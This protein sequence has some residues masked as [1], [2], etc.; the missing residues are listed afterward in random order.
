ML[1]WNSIN[2]TYRTK[3]AFVGKKLFTVDFD[4]PN[5]TTALVAQLYKRFGALP[6]AVNTN[7]SRFQI[8]SNSAASATSIPAQYV[9]ANKILY[10]LTGDFTGVTS[11]SENTTGLLTGADC[12]TGTPIAADVNKFTKNAA[13]TAACAVNTAGTGTTNPVNA[14]VSLTVDGITP[15]TQRSFTLETKLLADGAFAAHTIRAA[16]NF[17]TINRD[18]TFFS[19]NSTGPLNNIKITDHSGILPVAGGAITVTAFNPSGVAVS[20]LAAPAIPTVVMNNATAVINGGDLLAKFPG[21]N[22][23]DVIVESNAAN[24]TNVKN[25]ATGLD[26][27]HY[28]TGGGGGL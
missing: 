12:A 16:S 7:Q 11:I 5:N 9:S 19:S 26:T 20:A 1:G 4:T 13:G 15:Q 28:R 22:R 2:P 21:A 24:I 25:T 8:T 27:A 14:L 10:T 18:G 6:T 17:I 23:F 3:Y